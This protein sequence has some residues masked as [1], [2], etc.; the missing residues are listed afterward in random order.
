MLFCRLLLSPMPHGRVRNIDAAEALAM[1]GVLAVLAA[2]DL[3][4]VEPPQTPI[5]TNEPCY[6]GEPILAV[7]AVDEATAQN[8]IDTIKV[9]IEPL[10]FTVDKRSGA[11][12]RHGRT[13]RC[14]GRRG[15]GAPELQPFQ[16]TAHEKPRHSRRA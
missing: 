3:P 1:D 15:S 6:V 2:D 13:R 5:L 7:A 12:R 10:P 8:A 11:Q 16:N 14:S 4:P 9:D